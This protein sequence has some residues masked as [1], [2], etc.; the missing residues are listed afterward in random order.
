MKNRAQRSVLALALLAQ[1]AC[2]D[3]LSQ[4]EAIDKTRVVGAKVEVA[5]DATRAAPLPGEDVFVR[6]L[7]VAP[8]PA[9]SFAYELAACVAADSASDLT[10]C[11]G[12]PFA[13][14][15]SLTP[16]PDAPSIAFVAP[17]TATGNERLAVLGAICASGVGLPAEGAAE[18]DDGSAILRT[19]LDFSMDDGSHPNT[20]PTL[21]SVAFD[22][23]ELAAETAASADC[24]EL[25]GFAGGSKHRLGVSVDP[26]SR[27]ALD[28]ANEADPARESLLVSYF[29]TR[30]DLDHAFGAIDARDTSSA[31]SAIWTA[32][33][34]SEPVLAR[35]V[36][37]VRDGRGGS[38]FAERRLCILPR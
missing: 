4:V 33:A 11:A 20:N 23:D 18:C 1:S 31:T 6:F 8:D 27:D 26:S 36:V 12:E 37:V 34:V 7:V 3:P 5:G 38:D 25:P 15:A 17:P 14:S 30:G 16:T 2:D 29:V 10:T 19:T 21:T 13:T 24:A 35:F 32:P 9:P 22:G 28:R